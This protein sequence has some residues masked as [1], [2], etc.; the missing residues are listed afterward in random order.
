MDHNVENITPY[1]AEG[2]S[3]AKTE[4][5][6]DMFDSIAPA[7]DTMNRMMTMGIDRRW[8]RRCVRM[9]RD[10]RPGTILDLATGTG[11]LAVALA[12]AIP[13]AKVTG[14]DLSESMIEI[15]RRKV[16]EHGL[17]DRIT[18][19]T[20]DA[21]KMPFADDTFDA[22]TI[23]FGVRNFED[24]EAGYTEMCRVLRPGGLLVVLELTP[25]ASRVVKP[26]YNF[27]TRCII[28]AVGRIVSKDSRAY[29]YLP[30]SIA[31]VPARDAMLDIMR[32]AGFDDTAYRSLTLGVA[33]IYTAVKKQR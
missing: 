28:P 14:A 26:F 8:R 33:T 15:G 30:E 3:R 32:R 11:D 18:L 5:V 7:Y 6:R 21:L 20:A 1:A 13:D 24:L 22:M 9:V 29:T 4:Q 31:A 12:R 25:P 23:A 2:D 10:A 19:M 17:D 27:Y 16:A